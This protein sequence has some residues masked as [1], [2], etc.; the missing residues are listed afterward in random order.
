MPTSPHKFEAAIE[1]PTLEWLFLLVDA[2]GP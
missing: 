2:G 1:Q